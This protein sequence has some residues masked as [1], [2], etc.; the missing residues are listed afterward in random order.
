MYL[1]DRKTIMFISGAF[2]SHA[3]WKEWIVFFENKGYKTVAPPWLYKN[4]LAVNLR[5]THSESK[6]PL[7]R[8]NNLLDYYA[9]IIDKLPEK[10]ILIGHSYGGL[11]T[12]L[13]MQK[14]LGSHGICINSIPPGNLMH[15]NFPFYKAVWNLSDYFSSANKPFLMP[16]KTWQHYFANQLSFEEQKEA[17]EALLVP[18]SRLI[19]CEIY[20]KAAKID[21]K[22]KHNPLLFL[23]GSKDVFVSPSLNNLNF[24]KYKNIHSITCYKEFQDFNHLS[25]NHENWQTIADFI[26]SW[27]KKIS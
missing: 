7:I 22:K 12:Q 16:F 19:M 6:I 27:L 5:K 25:I 10:P 2:I 13:L 23:S 18:E 26:V 8:L 17:Y 20:S 11:L 4:E 14:E 24:K 9:E 1:S 3:C 21:F 15:F